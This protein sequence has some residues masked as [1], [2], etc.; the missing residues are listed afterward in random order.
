M[1]KIISFII[2]TI[3]IIALIIF[4][5][6]SSKRI[7]NKINPDSGMTPDKAVESW[8]DYFEK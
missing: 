4:S 1:R 7:F 2:G 3:L 6:Y 8:Y 5:Y